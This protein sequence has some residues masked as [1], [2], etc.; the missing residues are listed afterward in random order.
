MTVAHVIAVVFDFDDTLAPDTTSRLLEQHGIDTDDFWKNRVPPLV[1]EGFDPA[2][3]WLKLLV[4]EVGPGKPLGEL[5]NERLRELGAQIDDTYFPGIPDVF[6]DLRA[7]VEEVRDVSIEFY[8]ISGG[9][10]QLLL[11]SQV[12]Q[13]HF[14]GVYGSEFAEDDAGVIRYVKRCV[15]FTEK[16]RY[17]YEIN[18][19]ISVDDSYA[20]PFLVNK[21]VAEPDRRV[22]LDDMIYVGDGL[23]DIPCFSM[24]G[25]HGGTSFGV[26]D[27]GQQS[28]AKRAFLELLQPKRVMSIHAPRYGPNDDLGALLRAAVEEK[29][30]AIKV[31]RGT[32][33]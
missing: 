23:T 24:L 6:A 11:G 29:V 19:G 26:F 3:A 2:L 9:L 33:Y 32:V 15:T 25:A 31:R 30:A 22:R 12:V 20:N 1:E 7:S 4:D 27:P 18:K 13:D 17:L 10:R 28:K 8:V 14:E 16:T 5:S 21:F